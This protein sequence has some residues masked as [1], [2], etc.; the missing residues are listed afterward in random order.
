MG[1]HPLSIGALVLVMV[2]GYLVAALAAIALLRPYARRSREKA[3]REP[4][5]AHVAR[6]RYEAV[7][8]SFFRGRMPLKATL[9]FLVPALGVF[10]MCMVLAGPR[11][12][13]QSSLIAVA[14]SSGMTLMVF[15]VILPMAV[16]EVPGAHKASTRH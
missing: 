11:Y 13:W 3:A 7:R 14:V 8:S 16:P 12:W 15:Y 9:F 4:E 1:E 10:G 6:L 5:A 2:C